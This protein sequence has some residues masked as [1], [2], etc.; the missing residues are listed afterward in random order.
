MTQKVLI[1]ADKELEEAAV[2]YA[3]TGEILPNGKE[4]INFQ[5]EKAFRAGAQ[6]QKEHVWHDARE[7]MSS[8]KNI[9][10]WRKDHFCEII[11]SALDIKSKIGLID[12]WAYL[13][14]ILPK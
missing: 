11:F 3:A 14:D 8:N 5:E 9:L 12:K 4:L 2:E 7:E 6:W 13:S 1:L 10:I